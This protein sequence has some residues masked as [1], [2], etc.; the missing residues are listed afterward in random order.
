MTQNSSAVLNLDYAKL[1]GMNADGSSQAIKVALN[2]T[3]PAKKPKSKYVICIDPGH[4]GSDPGKP[5]GGFE[6]KNFNLTIAK[7]MKDYLES[8]R[9]PYPTFDVL[10]TRTTD[11]FVDLDARWEFANGKS[12]DIFVSIHCNATDNTTA[13][14]ARTFYPERDKTLSK[15]LAESMFRALTASLLPAPQTSSAAVGDYRVLNHTTMPA[16]LVECGFMSNASDL[17][18]IQANESN[19]GRCLGLEANVWCQVNL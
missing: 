3:L 4:G 8:I 6:E 18:I 16:T 1:G 2:Q 7:A 17:A 13:H 19:I 15:S 10:M 9:S 14:G 12:P 11:V 5:S